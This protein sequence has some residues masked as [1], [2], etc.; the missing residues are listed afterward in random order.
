MAE[1]KEFEM[2]T[3]GKIVIGILALG[4]LV[5]VGMVGA[6]IAISIF[7]ELPLLLTTVPVALLSAGLYGKLLLSIFKTYIE[8][9]RSED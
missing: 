1:G 8:G 7:E 6:I 5:S 9:I 2:T 3:L 4:F